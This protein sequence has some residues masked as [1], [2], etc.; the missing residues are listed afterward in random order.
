MYV[1]DHQFMSNRTDGSS[2]RNLLQYIL[3]PLQALMCRARDSIIENAPDVLSC[4][5]DTPGLIA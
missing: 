1:N 3:R 4:T 5:V 2:L